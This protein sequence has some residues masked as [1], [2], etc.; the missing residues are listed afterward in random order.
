MPL[1]N[2]KKKED[3]FFILEAAKGRCKGRAQKQH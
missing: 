3:K 2:K 1:N